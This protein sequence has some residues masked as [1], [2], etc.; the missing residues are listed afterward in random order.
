MRRNRR[1]G[2]SLLETMI[3]LAVMAL[4]AATLSAGLGSSAL[5]ANK[6][7]TFD[8]VKFTLEGSGERS[9]GYART[10]AQALACRA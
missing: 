3:A 10:S 1:A 4:I 6:S 8:C 2:I 9:D 5:R 7:E